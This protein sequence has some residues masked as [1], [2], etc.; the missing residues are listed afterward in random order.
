MFE[1]L[2]TSFSVALLKHRLD[3]KY[4]MIEKQWIPNDAKLFV[5]IN[6][7]EISKVEYY[8]SNK[9]YNYRICLNGKYCNI[10]K[11]EPCDSFLNK[12]R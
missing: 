5:Y 11:L 6:L 9:I 10:G 7:I 1:N 2:H 8:M 3:K 4:F 12:L